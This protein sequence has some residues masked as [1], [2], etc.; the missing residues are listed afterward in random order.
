[1]TLLRLFARWAAIVGALV[2]LTS[3]AAL[4]AL[5]VFAPQHSSEDPPGIT[6]RLRA[7]GYIKKSWWEPLAPWYPARSN[8]LTNLILLSASVGVAGGLA[9]TVIYHIRSESSRR[10]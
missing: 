9:A 1:M 10:E 5:V 2:F 7:A 8:V 6:A 4:V 3:Y